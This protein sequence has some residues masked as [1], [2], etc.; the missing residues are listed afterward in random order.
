[1]RAQ[2]AL[3]YEDLHNR[4]LSKPS[5]ALM[6]G[7]TAMID[8]T[9]KPPSPPPGSCRLIDRDAPPP[10]LAPRYLRF[11]DL[12]ARG[13]CSSR[14]TLYRWIREGRFPAGVLLSPRM[15]AW[16]EDVVKQW[17]GSRPAPRAANA[18]L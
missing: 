14:D 13:I 12:K 4:A 5:Q 17:L 2:L 16:P 9:S 3:L 1:M 7:D 8:S 18:I 6:P 11:P 15:R 10:P